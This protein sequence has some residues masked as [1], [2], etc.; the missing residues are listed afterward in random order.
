LLFNHEITKS[1]NHEIAAQH[2]A[3]GGRLHA[4]AAPR[5]LFPGPD[6]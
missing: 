2:P 5:L 3:G 1:H 6:V 4:N